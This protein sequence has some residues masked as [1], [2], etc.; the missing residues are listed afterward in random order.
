MVRTPEAV[1]IQVVR[2]SPSLWFLF[3]LK[4]WQAT[5]I[6]ESQRFQH[7]RFHHPRFCQY[8]RRLFGNA[9]PL[10]SFRASRFPCL[11]PVFQD[12]VAQ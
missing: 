2:L 11:S 9:F 1:H 6:P 3:A 8:P 5:T 7:P 10:G 4:F 12:V